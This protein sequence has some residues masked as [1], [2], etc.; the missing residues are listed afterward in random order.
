MFL[1]AFCQ[2]LE[3]DMKNVNFFESESSL[4]DESFKY[5]YA[6][7]NDK[8]YRIVLSE[9]LRIETGWHCSN[10]EEI[11]CYIPIDH[12]IE[13][14]SDGLDDAHLKNKF[15]LNFL[16]ENPSKNQITDFNTALNASKAHDGNLEIF[17]RTIYNLSNKGQ[18]MYCVYGKCVLALLASYDKEGIIDSIFEELVSDGEQIF[19]P[20][21]NGFYDSITVY[22]DDNEENE[23]YFIVYEVEDDSVNSECINLNSLNQT[24]F[25]N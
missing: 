22:C 16:K 11:K 5:Y 19:C 14:I 3:C 6:Q 24:I 2:A 10:E 12:F 23:E 17:W 20:F 4:G 15:Y 9:D 25:L 7:Y 18:E 1:Q 13:A 21:V 8:T